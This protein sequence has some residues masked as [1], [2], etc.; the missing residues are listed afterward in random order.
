MFCAIA[1]R[2]LP[3]LTWT[4][5]A[6]AQFQA[7]DIGGSQR[8]ALSRIAGSFMTN[9]AVPGLSVAI[10]RQGKL[11]YRQAFGYAD[12]KKKEPVTGSSLFRIASVTKPI[13]SVAI[14]SLI[15]Q[16][17]L[18]LDAK[19]FGPDA[20]LGT[21]YGRPPYNA[22]VEAITIEHLLTHTCGGWDKNHD[23]PMFQNTGMDHRALI[24]ATLRNR[25]LD[26]APGTHYAYS[27]FGFCL[28]GRVVER[29]TGT[30][31]A[32]YVRERILKAC[33]IDA[34]RI[35]GNS[36]GKRAPNEVRYYDQEGGDPYGID[37][38]RLD[39]AGGWLATPT[40]IV[41]FAMHVDGFPADPNILKPETI[42]VMTTG[43]PANPH[44]AKGWEVRYLVAHRRPPGMFLGLGSRLDWLLLGYIDE[45]TT[46]EAR[47]SAYARPHDVGHGPKREQ[48][49]LGGGPSPGDF[50]LRGNFARA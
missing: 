31:Y 36:A 27:N 44:Y 46:Y 28:L 7:D 45:H 8:E 16:Q 23:D 35:A 1:A 9:C 40:D 25:P 3:L 12:L 13:T 37:V 5:R 48:L 15:E 14:F 41:R 26:F 11:V 39:S 21:T 6:P 2:G 43:T 4:S 32:D 50:V 34:M 20:V 24:S 49:K 30:G 38:S 22:G 29:V 47:Y 18:S 42:A 33:E 19:V 10:A 17:K